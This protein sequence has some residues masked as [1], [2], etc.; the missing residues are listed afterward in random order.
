MHSLDLVDAQSIRQK[1]FLFADKITT[2]DPSIRC[3]HQ[4]QRSAK[5]TAPAIT[6][7]SQIQFKRCFNLL[8]RLCRGQRTGAG[9]KDV[10]A[11]SLLSAFF[12]L[13]TSSMLVR[14]IPRLYCAACL[15]TALVRDFPAWEVP[16]A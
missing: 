16:C 4:S 9:P 1:Y 6:S 3:L 7:R 13:S 10:L 5:A 2:S 15:P 12:H 11:L 14:S 8:S